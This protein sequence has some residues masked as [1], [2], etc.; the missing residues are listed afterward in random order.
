MQ[1]RLYLPSKL[2]IIAFDFGMSRIGIAIGDG[3]L[4]IPHPLAT[5]TGKNK[6]EKFAKIRD[7][8]EKWQPQKFVVGIPS[9]NSEILSANKAQLITNIKRFSN[10]LKEN[11]KIDVE[12]VN[13]EYSSFI[14]SSKLNEQKVFA[15]NQKDKVDAMAATI[16]L[17]RYFDE[18]DINVI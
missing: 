9:E 12:F 10:R 3:Y 16:I 18:M 13:E 2:T 4:K 5:V 14:A 11:F 7:L 15:L 6:F 17:Q 1:M 8:V